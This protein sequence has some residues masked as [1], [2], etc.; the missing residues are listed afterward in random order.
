MKY[1]ADEILFLVGAGISKMAPSNIPL[2]YELTKYIL[3]QSCG[4]KETDCIFKLWDEFSNTISEYNSNY[5]F[6]IP[7]LE[8]ILG[9]IDEIDTIKERKSILFG[10]K[11]FSKA[12]FNLNH[13]ILAELL[14]EGSNILT[15]NFDL[16][17]EHAYEKQFGELEYSCYNNFSK[18]YSKDSGTVYHI[19][20]SSNDSVN[21]LGA[22]VDKVKQG[23]DTE[24]E[25][26][27]NDLI[28]KS[29]LIIFLGYSVS[30]SFDI[31][32]YFESLEH[33]YLNLVFVQHCLKDKEENYPQNLN[34]LIKKAENYEL[35]K[36][37]TTE[38]L[39][40]I[41]K[42]ILKRHIVN[43]INDELLFDWKASFNKAWNYRY[44]SDEKLLNLLGVR[45]QIGFNTI[46]F[47]TVRPNIIDDIKELEMYNDNSNTRINMY[48]SEALRSFDVLKDQRPVKPVKYVCEKV[49]YINKEYLIDLSREC[50]YYFRKY[51]DINEKVLPE[52]KERICF[53]LPM[54]SDYSDYSYKNVQYIS[55]I[56]ASLKYKSLFEGRFFNRY[57]PATSENELLLALDISY[58]EGSIA[59]LTHG[60]LQCIYLKL[61][62]S[63]ELYDEKIKRSLE[64]AYKLSNL[65]G[66]YYHC[67]LIENFVNYYALNSIIN[68]KS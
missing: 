43:D 5:K 2:G 4:E 17:I 7:R 39:C 1:K 67:V 3:E 53:L 13:K 26:I 57:Y 49:D 27:L 52:D 31:T 6:P 68:L 11:S 16:C 51:K 45:F 38:Y 59:A 15:T 25:E 33:N 19:H 62:N 36:A 28:L 55:Y 18:Y 66:Y 9:C 30:D 64:T 22:T 32:P 37:D 34:R 14:A 20:G 58:I 41:Y 65:S 60:A 50:E 61:M 44:N 10:L 35:L 46:V 40:E 54:L 8:T 29:K 23:F 24:E 12:P 63:T 42:T 21:V 56:M 48:F 47:K